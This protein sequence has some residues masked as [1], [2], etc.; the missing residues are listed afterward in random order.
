MTTKRGE[1]KTMQIA[2][3]RVKKIEVKQKVEQGKQSL[4]ELNHKIKTLRGN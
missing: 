4:A 3:L 2:R 1:S